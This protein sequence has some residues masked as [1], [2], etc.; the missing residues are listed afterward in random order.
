L[1]DVKVTSTAADS[2]ITGDLTSGGGAITF[3]YG[4]VANMNLAD[5]TQKDKT[6]TKLIGFK[7]KGVEVKWDGI[8]ATA[9]GLAVGA[10]HTSIAGSVSGV[11][12]NFN[13]CRF[14]TKHDSVDGKLSIG[15]HPVVDPSVTNAYKE[16]D[17]N[18][19]ATGDNDATASGIP[20]Y[21]VRII[22]NKFERST[23]DGATAFTIA[24]KEVLYN[25]G[26]VPG[27]HATC[28]S[29]GGA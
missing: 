2:G 23:I 28:I 24:Y 25:N 10:S 12:A 8:A 26:V 20:V 21:V 6:D 14:V 1:K 17:P 19:L 3:A 15:E 18:V 9:T 29:N 4:A 27:S 22:S 7:N 5:A 16:F 11:S 13:G